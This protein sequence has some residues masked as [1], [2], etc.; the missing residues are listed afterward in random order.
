MMTTSL[1]KR[2]RRWRDDQGWLLASPYIIYTLIFFL[3]PLI[4]SL[5]LVFQQWD[6]ISPT[7]VFVGLANFKEALTS[8][9]V[10]VAFLNTYKFLLLLV[11]AVTIASMGLALIVHKIPRFKTLFAVGFFLPY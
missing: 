1:K 10:W 9:R 11:P 3:V 4:W 6:L 5:F 7:P 2:A 8:S